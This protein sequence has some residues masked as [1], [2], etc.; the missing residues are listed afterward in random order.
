MTTIKTAK[1]GSYK[2]EV[3]KN[4]PSGDKW[5]V[6]MPIRDG[7]GNSEY[8]AHKTLK[9]AVAQVEAAEDFGGWL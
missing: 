7:K 1:I 6:Q 5:G 9:S 2:A 4:A 3:I 8:T